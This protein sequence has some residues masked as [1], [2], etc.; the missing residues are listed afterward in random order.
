MLA[1][2]GDEGLTL[3]QLAAN[4]FPETAARKELL[5]TGEVGTV[6]LCHPFLVHAAQ[7]HRGARPRF[8]AQPP[9][10][11][12]EPFVLER[13]DGKYSPVELAI[14]YALREVT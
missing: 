3:R 1:P 5:A 12:A 11:P 10:L 7:P 9:L 8:L 13:E 14:K 6:Y 2:A 4:G